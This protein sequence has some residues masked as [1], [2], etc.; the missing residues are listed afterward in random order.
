MQQEIRIQF[1]FS[2][3]IAEFTIFF[4]TF[5]EELIFDKVTWQW[6]AVL[7]KRKTS[8]Y[9]WNLFLR[10]CIFSSTSIFQEHQLVMQVHFFTAT[11]YSWSFFIFYCGVLAVDTIYIYI[12]INFSQILRLFSK[13][14]FDTL[15]KVLKTTEIFVKN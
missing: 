13:P 6:S 5:L 11:R 15:Q 1:S 9:L 3:F 7:S 8:A 14:S 2:L 10:R 12:N 4:N